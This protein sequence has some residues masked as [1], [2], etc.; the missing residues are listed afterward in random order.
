MS[1]NFLPINDKFIDEALESLQEL[2][3]IQRKYKKLDNDT[4]M[5]ELRDGLVAK[6][7]GYTHIN[8]DKHGLDARKDGDSYHGYYFL[9]VKQ[10]SS[11]VSSWNIT[12][13]DTTEEKANLFREKNVAI[14]VGIWDS[15]ADLILIV[16]GQNSE[17]GEYLYNQQKSMREKRIRPSPTISI[18]SLIQTYKFKIMSPTLNKEEAFAYLSDKFPQSHW[19]ESAWIDFKKNT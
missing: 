5:N 15:I 16:Y 13:N 8:E 19:W 12:F 2:V 17:I 7:L 6:I 11:S 4:F 1:N 9:E 18:S 10:V 14:A 3:T